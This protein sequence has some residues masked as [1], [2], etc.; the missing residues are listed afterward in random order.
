MIDD[1]SHCADPV[2]FHQSIVSD[3]ILIQNAILYTSFEYH[4]LLA[5]FCWTPGPPQV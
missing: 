1:S 2:K 3:W 5:G 4:C